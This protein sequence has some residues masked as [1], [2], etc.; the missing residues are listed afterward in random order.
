MTLDE[1]LAQLGSATPGAVRERVHGLGHIT[2]AFG[3]RPVEPAE[4]ARQLRDLQGHLVANTRLGVPA[5]AHEEC[6]TGL[7]AYRAS[8]FPS[9]LAL[10]AT[11]DPERVGRM[12]A[13][14]GAGMRALGVHQGLSPLL[15]VVRDY[16]WGRVEETF[17]EDPYLVGVLGT[18]YVRGLQSAGVVATVKHFAGY[19]ASRAGRNLAPVSMG[20]REFA[21]VVLPPFEMAVREGGARAVMN[22]YAEVDGVPA[23]ANPHLLTTLLRD[24]WGFTGTVVSDYGAVPFLRTMHRVA[25]TDGEAGALALRAGIDVELAETVCYGEALA[26]L[27]RSGAVPENLVD[28]AARRVLR[29]KA[30]LGLLDGLPPAAAPDLDPPENRR[31]ARDLAER[32]VV[33][34]AN[35]GDALPM[36]PSSIAVVGPCA[37]DPRTFLGCYSFPNHVLVDGD[38]GVDVPTLAAALRA[39][40]P[41]ATLAHAPGCPVRD[42]DRSGIPAAVDAARDADVCVVAVGDRAGLFGRGTSGEGCDVDD[43]SL[44]GV[45]GELVDAVLASGTPVVLVV[46]SGRPYAPGR[47]TGAAAIVQAFFPGEEGGPALAGVLSGRVVPSGRLPVQIPRDP[48]GQPGTYLHPPLGGGRLGASN[49]D[50]APAFPFG[51]G[52]SYT[53]FVYTDLLLSAAE[54]PTDGQVDI[55]FTVENTGPRAGT[56]VA[57]LYLDD[58][59][60]QVTRPVAQL[61]GF[62]RVPLR[63]GQRARVTF[64][65]H[66]DRTAFTGADLRRVVEPGDLTVLIG[67]S[68]VDITLRGRFTIT[69][70]V[71]EVGPGRVLSTP[72]DVE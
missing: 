43:L 7:M 68:S 31:I 5:I 45:Q 4:G 48:G 39:E 38:P 13:A 1:K 22:S 27:V 32:S 29:L 33:L 62:A 44:P 72:F 54:V 9:A 30:E 34:L 17:G 65:L 53:D 21:D 63:P 28:R 12:A 10:A 46:V 58:P 56:E 15:D 18:A 55:S 11:F 52:L 2:R 51:H 70:E 8:V 61:A 50:P 35:A 42:A 40:F 16:R 69:G 66:A 47:Y 6:L 36:R 25:A 37:D 57:Q 59:V 14:I 3:G 26:R 19:A 67:R 49:L 24:E 64:H 41:D 71:R 60:A 23:G 20:P